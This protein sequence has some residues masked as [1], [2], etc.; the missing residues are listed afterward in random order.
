MVMNNNEDSF[1]REVNEELRSEQLQGFWKRF[2]PFIIGLA[3]IIVVG[4]AGA[5][6]YKFW[7]ARES[8][9]SSDRFMAAL[10]SIEDK[11]PEEAAKQLEALTK[12][13]YGAYPLLARMRFATLKAEKGDA[14]GAIADFIAIGQD[15]SLTE[16]VRNASKLRA[17]WLMVDNSTYEALASEIEELAK[18]TS[19]SRHAA[20]ETLGLSAYKAG[21]YAKA[22]EWLTL[23]VNDTDAPNGARTRARTVLDLITASGKLS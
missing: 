19:P 13:G 8:S 21:N 23:I 15:G 10:K 6:I 17:A 16:A 20:R 22:K 18:A 7:S 11:K 5:E 9:A 14:K 3:V 4:F 12:D 1:I 2:K